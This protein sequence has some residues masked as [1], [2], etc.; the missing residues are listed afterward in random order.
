MKRLILSE[1][2]LFK[3]VIYLFTFNISFSVLPGSFTGIYG[4]FCEMASFTVVENQVS[5]IRSKPIKNNSNKQSKVPINK[6][7]NKVQYTWLLGIIIIIAIHYLLYWLILNN[8]ITPVALKI[9]MN[10]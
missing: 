5:V 2:L 8:P 9:R 7:R 6:E 10:N 1:K 3:I 4:L